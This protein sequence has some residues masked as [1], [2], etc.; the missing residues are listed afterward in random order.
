VASENANVTAA[1]GQDSAVVAAA[2][3][4]A[5][6]GWG[7]F[8]V[9]RDKRPRTA[10]GLKDASNDPAT[11]RQWWA[12]WPDAGVAIRTGE[13]LLVLDVDGEDGGES[14]HELESQHGELPDTVRAVTGKGEHYYFAHPVGARNSA[15]RL[16][17][18]LDIRADGGYVVAPPSPHPNGR[19]YEWDVPPGEAG[20]ARAP[21]WLLEV[22][23]G[24][25]NGSAAKVGPTIP[26]GKRDS[27]LASLAGSMR[28]R[29]MDA[30]EIAA[31]LKVTNAERC[32]PPLPESEVERISQ[33]IARYEPAEQ[34]EP[35]PEPAEPVPVGDAVAAYQS[36][37]E[38]PDAGAVYA[39][40]GTVAA[41]RLDRDPVWTLLV[42]PPGWGKT[43]ALQ[44]TAELEDV[45]PTATLT[46]PAL[47]S[48]TAKRDR[49]R[50]ATGG[51]LNT[52]GESGIVLCKDFGSVLSMHREA[53][54]QVLAALREIYD[55]SWTR[56][57]GV[58]GGKTLSWQ[59]KVGFIG[60]CTPTIDRAHAVMA[61]MGE[62]FLLYRLPE[63]EPAKQAE[64]A[65]AHAG[66]EEEMR[67]ELARAV[68]GV[69]AAELR[70]PR[71]LGASERD[72]LIALAT[73]A[74]RA[75]SP[76]E[77]DGHS[78]EIELVPASE[79]PARL[80][81]VLES[82]LA[83]LDSL[84]VARELA[85]R[86]TAKA[87]LDCVPRLRRQVVELLTEHGETGTKDA[88]MKLDYPTSTTRRA[89]EDLTAHRI[90]RRSGGKNEDTWRLTEQA[91]EWWTASVPE[92]SERVRSG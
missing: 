53:R 23:A 49:E 60:G 51:L 19:R 38:M 21:A 91:S 66:R 77:R 63:V 8:P 31:A 45:Y 40:L 12:L 67:R 69:F 20:L 52:I 76:V 26:E 3:D 85:W 2:L 81:K 58:D 18:G 75:R 5:N 65:L 44:A 55:G 83:G 71:G 70:A 29:G 73:F 59:G 46:E 10:H 47:L 68:A 82:L 42:A 32:R 86:V 57:V 27:T 25:R 14:L 56:H 17:P 50:S 87:A 34:S 4:Y 39:I 72:R 64:R 11:I 35:A 54:G 30:A 89:L 22:S 33:S 15:G 90:V 7:V 9:R 92:T 79:A 1:A 61:T 24:R 36:W 28:R 48:G 43:E 41:H 13:G 78:R 84:G 62:R 16:G 88:A 80:A 6:R 37:L 74:V